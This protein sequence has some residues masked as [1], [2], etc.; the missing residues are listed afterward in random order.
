MFPSIGNTFNDGL[1]VFMNTST[2]IQIVKKNE[3]W[4]W[5][6]FFGHYV[7]SIIKEEKKLFRT[8]EKSNSMTPERNF[9]AETAKKYF[10]H[11]A[12]CDPRSA[13]CILI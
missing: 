13:M 3:T 5:L 9:V 7:E 8:V 10:C 11:I 12:K 1:K 6:R 2:T 4:K